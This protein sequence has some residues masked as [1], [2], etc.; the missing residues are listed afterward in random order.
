MI[1]TDESILTENI[2]QRIVEIAERT[3]SRDWFDLADA[4]QDVWLAFLESPTFTL[5]D[6]V[7]GFLQLAWR[8]RY[9]MIRRDKFRS[10]RLRPTHQ[11]LLADEARTARAER[12]VNELA[13]LLTDKQFETCLAV[14]A[15]QSIEEAAQILGVTPR[16]VQVCLS[17]I[18]ADF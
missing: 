7:S 13:S 11:Y 15:A 17:R 3:K 9:E 12:L 8:H 16:A 4:C 2:Y 18:R 14:V 5:P 1:G 10:E 6:T